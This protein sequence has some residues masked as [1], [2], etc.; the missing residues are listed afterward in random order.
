MSRV[1]KLLNNTPYMQTPGLAQVDLESATKILDSMA[2][3]R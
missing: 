1:H 3:K 2:N